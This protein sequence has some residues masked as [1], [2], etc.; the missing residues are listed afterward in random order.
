MPQCR[1]TDR[2]GSR[3]MRG[4]HRIAPDSTPSFAAVCTSVLTAACDAAYTPASQAARLGCMPTTLEFT[5]TLPSWPP[6]T[7]ARSVACTSA[8]PGI[9]RAVARQA[10]CILGVPRREHCSP[11]T[12]RANKGMRHASCK[13]LFSSGEQN[14]DNFPSERSPFVRGIFVDPET[15]V[16]VDI[17]DEDV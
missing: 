14:A 1:G 5:T 6:A 17:Q 8:V 13:R 15:L 16:F 10:R 2:Q 12:K 11:S 4:P 7:I 3:R 9:D